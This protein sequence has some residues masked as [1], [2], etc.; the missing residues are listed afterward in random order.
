VG[1]VKL[2]WIGHKLRAECDIVVDS[3]LNVV[4]AHAIAVA[5]EHRLIHDVPRLTAALVHADPEPQAG[6]DHHEPLADHRTS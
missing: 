6:T 3:S 5:A 1:A 4:D 2:R